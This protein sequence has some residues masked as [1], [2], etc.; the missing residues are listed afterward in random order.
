MSMV[1]LSLV[2]ALTG[3]GEKKPASASA[4]GGNSENLVTGD[5]KVPND[6]NSRSFAERLLR[7]PAKDFKP[8]DNNSGAKFIYHELNFKP[9]NTWVA[10]ATMYADGEEIDCVERG[11]WQMEAASDANTAEMTWTLNYTNCPSRPQN[12]IMRVKVHIEKGDYTVQ[13]H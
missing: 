9:N 3:C 10:N 13:F 6:E 7:N 5:T 2:L 1:A 8:T 12:N 11:E 4:G